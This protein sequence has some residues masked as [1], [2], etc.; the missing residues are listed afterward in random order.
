[1]KKDI[2]ILNYGLGNLVSLKNFFDYMGYKTNISSSNF[3][4]DI[5]ILPGV[6]SMFAGINNIN[7]LKIKKKILT[8]QKQNVNIIGICLGM[9]LMCSKGY[10]IKLTKGLG[11]FDA[12]VK[13][14][15]NYNIKLPHVGNKK[16]KFS[17]NNNLKTL[18][19]FSG[20]EFYFNHSFSVQKIP[21]KYLTGY[22]K[23]KNKLLISCFK[24]DKI[25]GFQFH[26]EKSGK[27]GLDFFKSLIEAI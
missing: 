18:N 21:N 16:V 4:S 11:L 3:N 27:I 1:M 2:T 12:D 8:K 13:S 19:Q 25:F 15:K 14:M 6:G 5:I 10:E 17:F 26:P 7:N 22:T 20:E 9:H 23:I 24:K